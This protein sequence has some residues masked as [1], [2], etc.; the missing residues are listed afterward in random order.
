MAAARAGA[1]AAARAS[2]YVWLSNFANPAYIGGDSRT[3]C[4]HRFEQR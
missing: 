4:R 2:L 1:S 3:A